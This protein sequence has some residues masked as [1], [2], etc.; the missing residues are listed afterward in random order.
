MKKILLFIALISLL[1]SCQELPVT[2]TDKAVPMY[3]D[4]TDITIP[5]NIAPLNFLLRNNEDGVKVI[6]NGTELYSGSDNK[7][8]FDM[9]EWKDF[10]QENA[11]KT[12]DVKVMAQEDGKWVGY[13]SF[14]WQIVKDSLDSYLTYRLIEPDYEVFNNLEIRQRC[15]EN[16]D[17]YHVLGIIRIVIYSC[18]CAKLIKTFNQHTFGVHIS[19]SKRSNHAFHTLFTPPVCYGIKQSF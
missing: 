4:Y 13:K 19:K 11:G 9:D 18:H 3:P 17:I 16:F 15:V 12:V 8:T 1:A 7:V 5:V 10:T 2:E 6:A 14:K